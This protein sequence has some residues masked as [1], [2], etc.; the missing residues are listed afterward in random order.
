[1]PPH[2][3]AAAAEVTQ[4]LVRHLC[5][6]GARVAACVLFLAYGAQTWASVQVWRTDTALWAH[7]VR[8]APLKPRPAL[9]LAKAALLEGRYADAERG[10]YRT[11]ALANQS[12]LPP[13]DRAD[14]I[15]AAQANLQAVTIVRAVF[16]GRP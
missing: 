2:S 8:Y 13:Y 14:A 7:A 5:G 12:H 6:R 15:A 1:M 9:N 11:L 3:G 16:A 10:L 4:C